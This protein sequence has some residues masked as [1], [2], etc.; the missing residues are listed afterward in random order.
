VS[1]PAV[2][3]HVVSHANASL[4]D[5]VDDDVFDNKVQPE[6]LRAFLD[7]PSNHLVVAVAE[8]QAIGMASGISYVHPEKPLALFI[9]EVGVS[10]RF[11]RQGIGSRLVRRLI[12]RGEELGCSEA[13]VGRCTRRWVVCRTKKAR[14]STS[15]HSSLKPVRRTVAS[16]PPVSRTRLRRAGAATP[17]TEATDEEWRDVFSALVDPLPRLVRAACPGMIARRSGKALVIGSASALRGMK[18]ASTYSAARG[19]QLAYVQAVGVALAPHTVQVLVRQ[20]PSPPAQ[21]G[22]AALSE[23]AAVQ[24]AVGARGHVGGA[25]A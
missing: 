15:M 17:A 7:N 22:E 23:K 1:S 4:F 18:R 16:N 8:G 19:A 21:S 20:T 14:S 9:N 10:G 24:A 25:R 11:R 6:L 5:S 12:E 2:S 3:I 13:W